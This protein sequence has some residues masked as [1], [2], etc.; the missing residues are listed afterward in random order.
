VKP[1]DQSNGAG[2]LDY[3]VGVDPHLDEH[4]LAIIAGSSSAV[5][6]QR[7]IQAS[8]RGTGS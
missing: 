3:A 1:E 4:L 8:A 7:S 5:V 2:E 6:A